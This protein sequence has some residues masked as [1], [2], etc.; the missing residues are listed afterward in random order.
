MFG[1][2]GCQF[3]RQTQTFLLEKKAPCLKNYNI[4][5]FRFRFWFRFRYALSLGFGFGIGSD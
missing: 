4:D 5:Q 3:E 1:L 2:R